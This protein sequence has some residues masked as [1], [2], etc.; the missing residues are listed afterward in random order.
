MKI[1]RQSDYLTNEWTGGITRQLYIHPEEA[2]LSARN[3]TL[4]ISSAVIDLTE[5]DFSDFTGYTRHIM[6][7]EGDI[8][9]VRNGERIVL[10]KD[11]LFRFDGSEKISSINSKGAT[12]FNII[13]RKDIEID[14]KIVEDE[15]ETDADHTT[16]VFALN[17][18]GIDSI[19]LHRH[20]T[21]V[22]EKKTRVN[23]KAVIITLP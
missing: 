13:H 22:T 2:S 15:A 23:G 4:R 18:C 9:L 5:S 14:T 10:E 7:L 1:Y 12:D 19:I 8:Q 3:F 20:E 6:P 17:D 11:R 16:I 21:L